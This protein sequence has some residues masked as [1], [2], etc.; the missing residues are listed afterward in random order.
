MPDKFLFMHGGGP[1]AVINASLAGSLRSLRGKGF[2]L[3][4]ARGGTGG[5]LKG[6]VISLPELDDKSLETLSRTPGSAIGTGRDHLEPEDYATLASVMKDMGVTHCVMTGGNGTMDTCRKLA[7]QASKKGVVVAGCP[8]TMDNDLSGTDHSPGFPSAARY[9]AGS[10]REVALDV[11]GLPIHVVVLEAFGRDAGWITAASAL[12]SENG[13]PGPDMVMLPE[14]PYDEDAFLSRVE[15]LHRRKG[16]VLVVA[17]EGLRHP[18]GRPIVD[19]V[20]QV[21]RSVYFGDVS[22]KLSQTIT[23]RLGIKSRGEKPGILGRASI[24]WQSDVDRSEAE[25]CGALSVELAL[26]GKAAWMSATRRIEGA[27]Y[28]SEAFGTEISDQVLEAKVMPPEWI[29]SDNWWVN[30]DFLDWCRPLAGDLGS[31]LTFV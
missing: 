31:H 30:G 11:R 19:P 26:D 20:F 28:A 17:S 3:L 16:G 10:A 14:V 18:D 25:A 22:A 1:T 23:K 27:P 7:Q 15:E 5:L 24:K 13:L 2:E 12:A 29:D 4:A 9:I 6:E 8:K 21:G